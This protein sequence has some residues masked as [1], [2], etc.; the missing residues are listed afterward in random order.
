M[1]IMIGSGNG[2]LPGGTKP[3]PESVMTY[4]QLEPM[5]T[6]F[7]EI[8]IEIRNFS[9][10]NM[11]LKMSSAK[12]RPF[13]LVNACGPQI[14]IDCFLIH[15]VYYNTHKRI[16][17]CNQLSSSVNQ[18]GGHIT[19]DNFRSRTW[20][21]LSVKICMFVCKTCLTYAFVAQQPLCISSR[22]LDA[23]MFMISAMILN[24]V[25]IT[26]LVFAM[27]RQ[28]IIFVHATG[29]IKILRVFGQRA[30][31]IRFTVAIQACSGLPQP[32]TSAN[33]LK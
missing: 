4:C 12:W 24:H 13:C 19:D 2:L 5:W 14:Y 21:E 22:N 16:N 11:H 8:F 17:M 31:A 18:D 15:T 25:V 27:S 29:L 26:V 7:T 28:L 20:P 6:I 33:W 30:Q 9:F 32:T 1:L 23:C 10:M 3:L